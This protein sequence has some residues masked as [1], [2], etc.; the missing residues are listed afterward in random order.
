MDKTPMFDRYINRLDN[1][2]AKW[3]SGS[4]T[5][6]NFISMS[7]ADMDLPAPERLIKQL[8]CFNRKG[9]YGYTVLP[10]NYFDVVRNYLERH[11][12]YK[13]KNDEIVFCPRIIQAISIYLR[14]FTQIGEKIC[15]FT[16]SYSPIINAI[17]LNNRQFLPCP[18]VY[19]NN[20]YAIDFSL[21]ESCFKQAKFFILISPHNPTGRVWTKFEL[22]KIAQLAEQYS[23]F[24]ISDDVH[25]DF[26]FS[27]T[28]HQIIAGINN[29]VKNHSI[30]CT[31]PAKTFNI[32][33]LEIANIIIHNKKIREKFHRTLQQLGIHNPNYFSI[34]AIM[35]AYQY[36]DNW[37]IQLK[38]YIVANKRLVQRFFTE[39]IPQLVVTPS[40]GTYLLWIN[41]QKLLSSEDQLKEKLIKLAQIEMAWGSDFGIEGMGFF[42]MN[43]AMPRFL[44]QQALIQ[45]KNAITKGDA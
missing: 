23:V 38:H 1:Y 8:E 4:S 16:P 45:I 18:L 37:I 32:P 7:V 24:I 29:Y 36:C 35:I 28:S 21:L 12:S 25:A 43:I 42:R 22:Q 27:E 17:T 11:Y 2:S 40:E 31:S 44:L 20:H 6:P 34:P 15:V 14:E 33:G 5:V 9:I 3:K 19:K 13:V 41:Y 30:I 26:T 10:E 39:E